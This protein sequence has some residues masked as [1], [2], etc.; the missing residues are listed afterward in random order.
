LPVLRTQTVLTPSLT[1]S[2]SRAAYT[3]M[4]TNSETH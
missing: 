3:R 2:S 1:S 4:I